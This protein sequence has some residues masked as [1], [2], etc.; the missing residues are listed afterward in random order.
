MPKLEED[1]TST[2]STLW[3]SVAV[4]WSRRLKNHVGLLLSR[5]SDLLTRATMWPDRKYRTLSRQLSSFTLIYFDFSTLIMPTMWQCAAA[6]LAADL[7]EFE[8]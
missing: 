8:T 6:A 3:P 5:L 2:A 4:Q 7:A 1:Q